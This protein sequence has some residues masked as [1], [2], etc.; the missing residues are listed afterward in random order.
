MKK[1]TIAAIATLA[2]VMPAAASGEVYLTQ[3]QAQSD[4]RYDAGE[5]YG[6]TFEDGSTIHYVAYCRPR[7]IIPARDGYDWKRYAWKIWICN[8]TDGNCN[9]QLHPRARRLRQLL[10]ASPFRPA[11][12]MNP[13][14]VAHSPARVTL[15]A[16]ASA[17]E[18]SQP[19]T[20]LGLLALAAMHCQP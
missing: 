1:M 3:R 10:L 14:A 12:P 5:R 2:L 9:G 6:H 11:M 7:G 4:A 20:R 15:N 19:P 18:R 13:R 17:P 16:A 8:W